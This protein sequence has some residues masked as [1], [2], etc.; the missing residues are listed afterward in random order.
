MAV[1][2]TNT[3]TLSD[4]CDEIGLTGVNRNLVKCFE[5][6][7]PDSFTNEYVG[8]KDRLSNFRNY[9][10]T[11]LIVSG[12]YTS[13]NGFSTSNLACD[14]KTA[15]VYRYFS[16]NT[17]SPSIGQILYNSVNLTYPLN[18]DNLWW[19]MSPPTG[20]KYSLKIN[21]SGEVIDKVICG[22]NP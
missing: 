13:P 15:T 14:D 6:A 10:H 9:T 11:P 7:N 12:A 4:V 5:M 1:P 18:G 3:F 8:N 22:T 19:Y 2:N 21:T 20:T 16:G 17:D